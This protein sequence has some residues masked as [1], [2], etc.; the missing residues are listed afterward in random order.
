M[1]TLY[2]VCRG[3]TY[4]VNKSGA[5][6]YKGVSPSKKWKFL[7]VSTHHWHNR[8]TIPFCPVTFTD[9]KALIRGIVWDLDHGTVR[10]WSGRYDGKLPRITNAWAE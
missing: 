1:K 8:V 6:W 7:G 4:K 9:P 3:E 2:F 5:L 10:R